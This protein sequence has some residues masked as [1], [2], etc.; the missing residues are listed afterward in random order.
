MVESNGLLNR[1][2]RQ[3]VPRVRIPLSP[4]F[5]SIFHTAFLTMNNQEQKRDAKA[6]YVDGFVLPLR[7]ENLEAYRQLAEEVAGMWMDLGALEYCECV[8]EDLEVE[9]MIPFPKF[10]A[11]KKEETVV[12][13]Y[14]VWPSRE[15]R[16]TRATKP[17]WKIREAKKSAKNARQLWSATGWLTA[18]FPSLCIGEG[19]IER[20][21]AEPAGLYLFGRNARA[22]SGIFA[23]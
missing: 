7:K 17:L 11:A 14:V 2:T 6:R 22:A 21:S 9:H 3:N 16:G 20:R 5:L 13:A 12:F 15:A 23:V 1:R 19:K 10:A 4:P 8:G 18:A